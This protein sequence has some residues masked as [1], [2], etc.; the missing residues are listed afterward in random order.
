MDDVPATCFQADPVVQAL[1]DNDRGYV[2][3]VL[4]AG[5]PPQ[6]EINGPYSTFI[7]SVKECFDPV[8]LD[9]DRPAVYLYPPQFLHVTIATFLSIQTV[10]EGGSLFENSYDAWIELVSTTASQHPDW[11]TSPLQLEID[12]TE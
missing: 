5:W 7:D 12:I 3:F 4:V 1:F 6:T 8:D 9:S 11:P 10:Q 2:G